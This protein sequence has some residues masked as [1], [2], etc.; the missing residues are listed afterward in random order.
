V[1]LRQV[2]PGDAFP[3][4][5]PIRVTTDE[6]RPYE[7]VVKPNGKEAV[8][9]VKLMNVMPGKPLLR[10]N[11]QVDPRKTLLKEVTIKP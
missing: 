10:Y 7:L 5:V 1:V 4:P 8:A 11:V 2:Q 6:G 3:D 9:S